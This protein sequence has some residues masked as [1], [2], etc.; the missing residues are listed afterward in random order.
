MS[1]TCFNYVLTCERWLLGMVKYIA[2][3]LTAWSN[4]LDVLTSYLGFVLLAVLRGDSMCKDLLGLVVQK[5]IG[6]LQAGRR[7]RCLRDV[8]TSFPTM[9]LIHL[10]PSLARQL[11]VPFTNSR[12]GPGLSSSVAASGCDFSRLQPCALSQLRCSSA[13]Y[14]TIRS[15]LN[16]QVIPEE[17]AVGDDTLEKMRRLLLVQL[18][19]NRLARFTPPSDYCPLSLRRGLRAIVVD[20]PHIREGAARLEVKVIWTC[21]PSEGLAEQVAE[22]KPNDIKEE[23]VSVPTIVRECGP[24]I[25]SCT[26]LIAGLS[27]KKIVVEL[28][29]HGYGRATFAPGYEPMDIAWATLVDIHQIPPTQLP[30]LSSS[31]DYEPPDAIPAHHVASSLGSGPG[32]WILPTYYVVSF[33]GPLRYKTLAEKKVKVSTF[34][35]NQNPYLSNTTEYVEIFWPSHAPIECTVR[36]EHFDPRLA[37]EAL[38]HQLLEMG[39]GET[40]F[41]VSQHLQ[42]GSHDIQH[43]GRITLYR[44]RLPDGLSSSAEHARDTD[45]DSLEQRYAQDSDKVSDR[46]RN[47]EA[48]RSK[49]LPQTYSTEDA[50]PPPQT[51]APGAC[52]ESD[53]PSLNSFLANEEHAKLSS[54]SY[55]TPGSIASY[56]TPG[57]GLSYTTALSSMVSPGLMSMVEDTAALRIGTSRRYEAPAPSMLPP[58]LK[59]HNEY[60]DFLRMENIVQPFD[61]ELNWSGKGQHVTF[62]PKEDVPLTLL[63]HLGSSIT[64]KVDKMLCRRI[65]VAKKTMRCSRGSPIK[66]AA[67]EVYHLQNLRHFHIVQLVGSYLQGRDFSILMYPVADCHLGTF[68]EDTAD[69]KDDLNLD[70]GEVVLEERLDFMSHSMSCL[71]SALAYVHDRTTKHMDIKPQNILVRDAPFDL[72]KWRIYLADFGLSRSFAAQDHSQTDGPTSRTPRYCAPE[73]YQYE[74]RGRSAD[75]FSLG[76]VFAEILTVIGGR[77]PHDFADWRRNE[78]GDESF[79]ANLP[80]VTEWLYMTET[81]TVSETQQSLE[82]LNMVKKML[83]PEPDAR[84]TARELQFA[85]GMRAV[86][87]PRDCCALEPESYVAHEVL[88]SD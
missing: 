58:H 4:C 56:K 53:W 73:V 86:F 7:S 14:P 15:Q 68:M 46:M 65:A 51:E 26:A 83:A 45:I 34:R 20:I 54:A 49:R 81:S 2:T 30:A 59:L 60:V 66:D 17:K 69:M 43:G 47:Y 36:V 80:K 11:S 38:V 6:A 40:D 35:P 9:L 16:M 77:H 70:Y 1:V 33:P 50:P 84:P 57:S 71:T 55:W 85:S 8:N 63:S 48:W 88:L 39:Y 25:I 75:V 61:K 41:P 44:S 64:A 52:D 12:L 42:G 67:R 27:T 13:N 23:S 78:R 24:S 28:F 3:Q 87:L 74:L 5:V 76:C 82:V 79:H 29:L 10:F 19:T 22:I 31:E 37:I 32:T 62:L 21:R 18:N 72:D